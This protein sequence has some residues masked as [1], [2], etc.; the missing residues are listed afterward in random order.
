MNVFRAILRTGARRRSVAQTSGLPYHRLAVGSGF[1]LIEAFE[2]VKPR[3]LQACDTADW[4]ACA[5]WP[6][7]KETP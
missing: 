5:T 3:R 4:E 6:A 7:S 1:F 2:L